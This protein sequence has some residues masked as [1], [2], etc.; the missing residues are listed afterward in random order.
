[1]DQLLEGKVVGAESADT[2]RQNGST[3][4]TAEPG[5]QF[6][7]TDT[8]DVEMAAA[9]PAPADATCPFRPI[10]LRIHPL[11]RLLP[12]VDSDSAAP[13]IEVRLELTDQFGDTTKGLGS[14]RLDL[15]EGGNGGNGGGGGRGGGRGL[16]GPGRHLLSWE[17]EFLEVE[18]NARQ[19]DR[20]TRTYVFSLDLAAGVEFSQRCIL[21]ATLTTHD[22][23]LTDRFEVIFP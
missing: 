14:L 2:G 18:A 12:S 9:V 23:E 19:F 8:D 21:Q 22:G 13:M 17:P 15:F 6:E 16:S 5:I 10:T 1:M 11:T 3:E 20:V 7:S 4:A